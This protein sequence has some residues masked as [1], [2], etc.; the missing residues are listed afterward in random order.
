MITDRV[1]LAALP[2]AFESL[3]ERGATCKLMVD[4]WAA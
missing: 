3:R 4:P 1:S 2:E